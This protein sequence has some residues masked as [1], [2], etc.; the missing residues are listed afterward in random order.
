[1]TLPKETPMIE[2]LALAILN[3]DRNAA[4]LRPVEGRESIPDSEGYVRNARAV[5]TALL[6]P[7]PEMVAEA[8]DNAGPIGCCTHSPETAR[9]T[10]QAML[11]A[12]LTEG[13][14]HD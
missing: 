6:E 7:T 14:G 4:G 2:R 11:N 9:E 12:A 8:V 3:D 5:L 1:M 10:W 13:E